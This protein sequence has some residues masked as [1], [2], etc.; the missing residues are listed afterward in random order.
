M[1]IETVTNNDYLKKYQIK[2]PLI[3]NYSY[4]NSSL[5][6]ETFDDDFDF[7]T[8]FDIFEDLSKG[9]SDKYEFVIPTYQFNKEYF[10]K[11]KLVGF[12]NA[13]IKFT[14]RF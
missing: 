4:L 5:T 3:N 11:S 10:L 12:D 7:A 8:S 13:R 9:E 14:P 6:F 2:S 1:K